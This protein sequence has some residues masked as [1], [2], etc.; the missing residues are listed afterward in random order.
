M[1]YFWYYKQI[2][3]YRNYAMKFYISW[4]IIIIILK[5]HY[6]TIFICL[7]SLLQTKVTFHRAVLLSHIVSYEII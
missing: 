4:I 5:K 7:N 3:A 1:Q 6:K 2:I